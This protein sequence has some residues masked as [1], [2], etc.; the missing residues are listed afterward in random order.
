M[1]GGDSR[2]G[3]D[4]GWPVP[5]LD[6]TGQKLDRRVGFFEQPSR[7]LLNADE[8]NISES[9]TIKLIYSKRAPIATVRQNM[10][11]VT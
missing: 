4:S 2:C 11:G 10:R 7:M 9:Y 3:G 5:G 1:R 6:R 8:C